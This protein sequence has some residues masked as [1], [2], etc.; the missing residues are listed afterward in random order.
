M[1]ERKNTT[2][3]VSVTNTLLM[4]SKNE[5]SI[6][7]KINIFGESYSHAIRQGSEVIII[8]RNKRIAYKATYKIKRGKLYIFDTINSCSIDPSLSLIKTYNGFK[9]IECG[10]NTFENKIKEIIEKLNGNV[11]DS[12]LKPCYTDTSSNLAETDSKSHSKLILIQPQSH[13]HNIRETIKN[14]FQELKQL[15]LKENK[16][17]SHFDSLFGHTLT[18][19]VN[20]SLTD[21]PL[22]IYAETLIKNINYEELFL[23]IKNEL[24]EAQNF[25]FE[26]KYNR[27]INYEN[28]SKKEAIAK[29]ADFINIPSL[30]EWIHTK[31]NPVRK[32]A[33]TYEL[34][35]A[36]CIHD[37]DW[38]LNHLSKV[39]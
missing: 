21:T 34:I 10:F 20:P 37:F 28:L 39:A 13:S 5:I 19:P 2:V 9:R 30:T 26:Y 8:A 18:L 38:N 23:E 32:K 1:M 16:I 25:D 27:G 29:A 7:G 6:K 35:Y 36:I 11:I 12:N 24:T 22:S 14:Q 17:I 3:L 31:L 33:T 15:G 4:Y